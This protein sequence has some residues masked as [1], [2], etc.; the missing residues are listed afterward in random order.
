MWWF[1]RDCFFGSRSERRILSKCW[2]FQIPPRTELACAA[3]RKSEA[4]EVRWLLPGQQ[5]LAAV[6]LM[7][8]IQFFS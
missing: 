4:D 8:A 3:H 1:Y 7:E 5:E 2:K 6:F